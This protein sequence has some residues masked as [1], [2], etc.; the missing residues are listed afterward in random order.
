MTRS[1]VVTALY[2]LYEKMYDANLKDLTFS[3]IETLFDDVRDTL[4]SLH[5]DAEQEKAN[6]YGQ[7]VITKGKKAAYTFKRR[8]IANDLDKVLDQ[9]QDLDATEEKPRTVNDALLDIEGNL[10]TIR[11]GLTEKNC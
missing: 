1:A 7:P 3:E 6:E 2:D 4:D 5:Y 8:A 10:I 11:D 9:V